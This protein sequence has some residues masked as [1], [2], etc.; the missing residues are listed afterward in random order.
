MQAAE[1]SPQ[2]SQQKSVATRRTGAQLT[3]ERKS[4]AQQLARSATRTINDRKCR[5]DAR[6]AIY[7]HLVPILEEQHLNQQQ[8]HRTYR[9]LIAWL[10]GASVLAVVVA[11]LL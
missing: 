6:I 9:Q 5:S 8:L 2:S 1:E 10:C 7:N 3:L 4:T 11:A